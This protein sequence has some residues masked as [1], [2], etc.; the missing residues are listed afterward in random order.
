MNIKVFRVCLSKKGL[1]SSSSVVHGV[2]MLL[3]QKKCCQTKLRNTSSRRRESDANGSLVRSWRE[4]FPYFSIS[5]E[6][7]FQKS[8]NFPGHKQKKLPQHA[9]VQWL[10]IH[11][12]GRSWTGHWY[13]RVGIGS[14]KRAKPRT[15]LENIQRQTHGMITSAGALDLPWVEK[16]GQWQKDHFFQGILTS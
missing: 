13:G 3:L 1:I 7:L 14:A 4:G 15:E 2:W 10:R 6:E 11:S 16:V 8:R 12:P 5:I 9:F